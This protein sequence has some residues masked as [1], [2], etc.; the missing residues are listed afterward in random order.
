MTSKKLNALLVLKATL[1]LAIV[2]LLISSAFATASSTPFA[3]STTSNLRKSGDKEKVLEEL[4][5]QLPPRLREV[6]DS[7]LKEVEEIKSGDNYVKGER[8]VVFKPTTTK[9]KI[10][11]I[12]T[13]VGALSVKDVGKFGR[14]DQSKT[15]KLLKFKSEDEAKQAELDLK[16]D[17]NVLY[18]A[19]NVKFKAPPVKREPFKGQGEVD[20]KAP[21]AD[22]F[23]SYQWY[24]FKTKEQFAPLTSTAPMVAVIDTGVQYN[25][26]ELKGKVTLGHDYVDDD[27]DPCDENG[28]GTA[29]AG[30]IGAKANNG[31]GIAGVSPRS[32]IYAIRVLDKYGSGTLDDVIAGILEAA[33][34]DDVKVINLSLGGYVYYL[35]DEYN[36]TKEVIDYAVL[37][38]GK[39]VVSAAGNEANIVSY[40]FD[41]STTPYYD[42]VPVPAAVPSSFTV[43]ATDEVD[44]R[45]WF[46]NYGTSTLNYV[47]IAAPGFRILSLYLEGYGVWYGGTSF[48]APIVSGAVAR[49][50]AQ[51]S[52][53]SNTEVMKKLVDTGRSLGADKGFP[54]PVKRVDI[55]K[56]LG[57]TITGIQGQIIDAENPDY[58][59]DT[60]GG[61]KVSVSGPTKKYTFSNNGGFFT[62]TGLSPGTYT[63]TVSKSGF[64]TQSVKV[65]VTSGSV[66]E[67][68]NFYMVKVKPPE[69]LTVVTTWKIADQGAYE[70]FF[71]FIW[72]LEHPD[73]PQ[74][75]DTAGREMNAN[76]RILPDNIRLHPYW[77]RGKIDGYPYAQIVVDSLWVERPVE[78][79]VYKPMSGKTYEYGLGMSPY[80]FC[81]G[82]VVGSGAITMVFQSNI[83]MRT[84]DS[85]ASTG[86]ADFWW[87][88]FKQVGTGGV[89]VVNKR[90]PMFG[91]VTPSPLPS[92]I[93]VDDDAS[94]WFH[95]YSYW[96]KSA[97]SDAGYS[98]AYWNVFEAGPPSAGDLSPYSTIIWFTGDDFVTVLT[99]YERST[100]DRYLSSS[101]KGLF[102]TGQDVGFYLNAWAM[103][104]F[105]APSQDAI[106]WYNNRL[107]AKFVFDDITEVKDDYD[108]YGVL[109]LKGIDG[110]PISDPYGSPEGN[111][112]MLA[113]S[114][115]DGADNQ[116]WA[117][118][119]V[120]TGDSAPIFYYLDEEGNTFVY[121]G[122]PIAGG[123]R[124][125]SQVPAPSTP[126]RLVYLSFGFE[127]ISDAGTRAELMDEIV[128]FLRTGS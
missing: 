101:G 28:H 67:D 55:A 51:N 4:L 71:N 31:I 105:Y 44:A 86:T 83:I 16:K 48:A 112:M 41:N 108:Y 82:K 26:P 65:T 25:H 87:Y 114:D 13:K 3:Q 34:N 11:D 40:L 116:L 79:V 111:E 59:Y 81:W 126:Y 102:I 63:V 35:S 123:V 8:I 27:D 1:S 24:L 36:L 42:V 95:D 22:P 72:G 53:L 93:L 120:P 84:I 6:I 117:D 74:W 94:P 119:I 127:A 5:E 70:W 18:V 38:K 37:E 99:N 124:F 90:Q 33:E 9:E 39:V 89:T 80:D 76:L 88:V 104:S 91:V 23:R 113:I 110:D 85:G 115:G 122:V 14:G 125:P 118:G 17:P 62:I 96:F 2:G 128:N 107:K 92:I 100:L 73:L 66:T 49:V 121:N 29:V 77:N 10:N 56:A 32:M 43:A 98:F 50:W 106:S 47:D 64:V 45:T 52:S 68:V 20:P 58:F 57:V 54:I 30:V 97:L 109:A 103:Y 61:V 60:L 75:Q 7:L 21:T 69:Y 19:K 15:I 46:S 78:T 12:V